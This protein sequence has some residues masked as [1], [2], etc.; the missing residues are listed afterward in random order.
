MSEYPP[1]RA[2]EGGWNATAVDPRSM[3]PYVDLLAQVKLIEGVHD[4]QELKKLS[5]L[6][7]DRSL[8]VS[9]LKSRLFMERKYLRCMQIIGLMLLDRFGQFELGSGRIA[10]IRDGF[11]YKLAFCAQGAK[12]NHIESQGM[13]GGVPI[14]ATRWVAVAGVALLQMERVDPIDSND[15]HGIDLQRYPW[16]PLV[17]R[18]QVGWTKFGELV[19]YDAG[20]L[21]E[22]NRDYWG[23]PAVTAD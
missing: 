17:D 1:D 14:A 3:Q 5:N 8:L 4:P 6:D 15:R 7:L 19:C 11:V 12:A 10:Y 9:G 22:F 13:Y 23:N 2:V 16:V 21:G 18:C 20:Q